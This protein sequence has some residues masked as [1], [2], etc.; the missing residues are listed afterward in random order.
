MTAVSAAVMTFV[1]VL[2]LAGT[3]LFGWLPRTGTDHW[4]VATAF[5]TAAAGAVCAAGV[6]WIGRSPGGQPSA[7]V[8]RVVQNAR[9]PRG[10]VTQVGGGQGVPP[11]G[12]SHASP[13]HVRQDASAGGSIIQIGGDVHPPPGQSG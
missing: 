8:G 11:H 10:R 2:W 9:T 12:E 7:A 13:R 5:A 3:S 4:T 6:A 1:G